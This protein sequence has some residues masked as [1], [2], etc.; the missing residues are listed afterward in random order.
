MP[1]QVRYHSEVPLSIDTVSE[2]HAEALQATVNEGL[3]QGPYVMPGVG[4]EPSGRKAPTTKPQSGD[5]LNRPI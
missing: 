5:D 3:A 1:L 2:K 4:F